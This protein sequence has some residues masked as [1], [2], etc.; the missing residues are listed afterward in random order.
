MREKFPLKE[1]RSVLYSSV[2]DTGVEEVGEG[3]RSSDQIY[4]ILP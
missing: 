4:L 2:L 3:G 1:T